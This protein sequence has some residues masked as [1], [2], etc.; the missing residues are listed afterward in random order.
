MSGTSNKVMGADTQRPKIV[1]FLGPTKPL[2]L[3]GLE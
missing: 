2:P 1:F 3:L